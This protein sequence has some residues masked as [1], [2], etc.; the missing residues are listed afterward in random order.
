M[1]LRR[2]DLES[3]LALLGDV[4]ELDV[5][6][7]YSPALLEKLQRLIA[8]DELTYQEYEYA[9]RRSCLFTG[10][11]GDGPWRWSADD[12]EPGEPDGEDLLYWRLGPCPIV[13]YRART[14]ELRAVRM[15]DVISVRRFRELPIYREFFHRSGLD[16]MLDL[17]LPQR[18]G[19]QRSLILFRAPGADFSDRD[20]SV[21]ELLRPHLYRL[22]AQALLRRDLAAALRTQEAHT[23][24]TRVYDQLTRRERQIVELVASGKTNAEIASGLWV[25]P[26]TVK[27]H[28]EHIY[29]KV[30]VGRRAALAGMRKAAPVS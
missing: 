10:V 28:L 14:G 8:C 5:T 2:Q 18:S 3:V 16:H 22:E 25:A 1:R 13:D 7:P 23:A 19:R 29:A 11:A 17:G 27:K 12:A 6:E 20:A 24:N 4:E 15:S 21:L 30:G 9:A 26:S